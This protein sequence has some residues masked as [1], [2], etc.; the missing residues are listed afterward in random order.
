ML[1]SL[2]ST[3]RLRGLVPRVWDILA[4]AV[5]AFALWKIFIAPR[6]LNPAHALPAPHAAYAKL[7]GGTFRV[8]DARGRVLFL[9][10]F[11]SW[12]EPC[13]VEAPAV[14]RWAQDNP[15]AIVIPIDVGEP[16]ML[17]ENFARR[18]GLR[19]VGLDPNANAQ[20]LFS[21]RGF[22]TVVV[23]DPA[24][25]I[26]ATWEGL[27]PAIALAMSN[28]VRSLSAEKTSVTAASP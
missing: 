20:A 5:V 27:N 9:D 1:R 12:C 23:I 17:A 7:D 3:E 28:A 6:D 18:Y 25:K 13:K 26:R 14:A 21:V 15:Q 4:V 10:F 2:P 22:P 24:G 16:R 8:T 19:D 11:A